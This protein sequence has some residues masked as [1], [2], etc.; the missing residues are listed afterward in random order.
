MQVSDNGIGLSV[1]QLEI[2][3]EL[4]VQVDNSLARANGG[5]G[6]GLTLVQQLVE[7]HGGRVQAQS[8]GLGQGSTFS[9]YL[10]LD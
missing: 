3:F 10:P 5:L 7:Q 9:V 6:L 8:L 4:F 2:I 1:D